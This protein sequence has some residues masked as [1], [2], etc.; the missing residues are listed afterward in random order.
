MS[1]ITASTCVSS[2][3]LPWRPPCEW[4]T[5]FPS[6]G[7]D[8]ISTRQ[9]DPEQVSYLTL[10]RPANRAVDQITSPSRIGRLALSPD[11][12]HT[13]QSCQQPHPRAC[14]CTR[15]QVG[16]AHVA[17]QAG[18]TPRSAAF[19]AMQ[20]PRTLRQTGFP[21]QMFVSVK[22]AYWHVDHSDTLRCMCLLIAG[23]AKWSETGKSTKNAIILKSVCVHQDA[24][25]YT[26][27]PTLLR[28]DNL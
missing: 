27:S 16:A 6:L 23:A 19:W 8:M 22:G 2:P 21:A 3:R 4:S 13:V 15:I 7:G 26:G 9:S 1:T 24:R 5:R 12:I 25:T 11:D 28:H 10:A 17:G 14:A 20:G 18:R